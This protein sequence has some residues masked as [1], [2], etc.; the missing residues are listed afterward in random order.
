MNEV[1][2]Q[3]ENARSFAEF[4]TLLITKVQHKSVNNIQKLETESLFPVNDNKKIVIMNKDLEIEDEVFEE[5]IKEEY[6]KPLYEN[7]DMSII[8][9]FNLDKLLANNFMTELKEA[10]IEKQKSMNE[11]ELK[12]LKRMYDRV[13]K[14]SGINKIESGKYKSI[15]SFK[16]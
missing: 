16:I 3:I 14:D 10:L 15:N 2:K 11:R 13:L 12:A 6:L 5:Y 1:Y 8:Q 7:T 9:D 4:S